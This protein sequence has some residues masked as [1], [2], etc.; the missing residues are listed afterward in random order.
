[1]IDPQLSSVTT[2]PQLLYM[3]K[4]IVSTS[5]VAH[6]FIYFIIRRREDCK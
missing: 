2:F 4:V 3:A 5:V 6:C 1:M